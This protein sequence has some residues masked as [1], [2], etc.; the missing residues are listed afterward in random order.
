MK[1]I[2]LFICLS[3]FAATTAFAADITL[4]A[5]KTQGGPDILS[6]LKNRASAPGNGF[7][8]GA[9]S[10]EDLSTLL[11]AASGLNR[12]DKGWTVPMA[13]GKEPY[14][15][16]Y[17]VS[18]EGVFRYDWK[19]HALKQISSAKVKGD[20]GGQGW[21]ATAPYVLVFVANNE[22][23][24]V[25]R[26]PARNASFGFVLIGAM[27]QNVYLAGQAMGIGARYAATLDAVKVRGHLQ[28]KEADTPVCIMPIGGK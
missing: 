21:V 20:L 17:V 12:G 19:A 6:A 16:I 25:F 1:K 26:D 22:K 10:K 3:V 7:P 14:C 23:L 15:D 11:W 8:T 4:P 24:S 9:V 27:T 5:P 13:M 2:L 28:L 18:D